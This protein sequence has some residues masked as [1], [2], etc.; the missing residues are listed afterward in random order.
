MKAGLIGMA[1]VATTAF[2]A[3][4]WY[5]TNWL[6]QRTI[7]VKF[8][9]P[10]SSVAV[11]IVGM[12]S[13]KC[14]P[15]KSNVRVMNFIPGSV[16]KNDYSL[17]AGLNLKSIGGKFSAESAGSATTQLPAVFKYSWLDL[18]LSAVH[19]NVVYS[20]SGKQ[21]ALGWRPDNGGGCTYP[22]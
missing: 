15:P 20:R 1:L 6:G 12:K 13:G 8:E 3:T 10:V 17:I 16:V 22:L 7:A 5:T 14:T 11:H 4:D 2:G 19:Y 18:S 21:Y 9:Q